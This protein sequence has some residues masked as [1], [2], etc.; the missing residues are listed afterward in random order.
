MGLAQDETNALVGRS[1]QRVVKRPLQR[2]RPGWV[3]FKNAR[4]VVSTKLKALWNMNISILAK[5]Q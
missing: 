2:N 3:N 5:L 4:N 1:L